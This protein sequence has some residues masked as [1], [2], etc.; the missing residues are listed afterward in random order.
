MTWWS[1]RSAVVERRV[2]GVL[3]RVLVD[4]AHAWPVMGIRNGRDD[5]DGGGDGGEERA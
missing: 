5:D 4:P 2:W 1:T 3:G